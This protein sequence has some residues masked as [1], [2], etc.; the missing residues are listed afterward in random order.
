MEIAGRADERH[1]AAGEPEIRQQIAQFA[2]EYGQEIQRLSQLDARLKGQLPGPEA[3][4]GKLV[5]TDLTQRM[6]KFTSRLMGQ[7][8]LLDGIRRLRPTATG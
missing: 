8:A 4:I 1:R 6:V 5:S 7:Y 2:I 3:S